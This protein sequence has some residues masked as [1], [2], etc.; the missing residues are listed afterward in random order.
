LWHAIAKL[1]WAFNIEPKTDPKT[2]KPIIPD[3]SVVTGYREGLTMCPY[4]FPAKI[5]VR[6]EERRQVISKDLAEAQANFFPKYEDA[7]LFKR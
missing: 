5:T 2:S 3:A 7:D 4:E 1:L 6:S